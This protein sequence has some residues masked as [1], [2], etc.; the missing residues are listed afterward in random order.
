MLFRVGSPSG[1]GPDSGKQV[2][3]VPKVTDSIQ[4]ERRLTARQ[5]SR[6]DALQESI[7]AGKAK[8]SA[9]PSTSSAET[10]LK[11]PTRFS[12]RVVKRPRRDLSPPESPAK[13]GIYCYR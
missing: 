4:P 12:T 6:Q 2:K 1:V 10:T 8:D 5:Q 13:K 7:L 9:V 3:N 11:Q